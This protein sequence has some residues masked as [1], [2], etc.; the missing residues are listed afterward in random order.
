[1]TS[2]YIY[3]HLG[4][5]DNILC[6]GLIR[7]ISESYNKVYVFTKDIIAA[8]VMFMYK[9]NPK[10][11]IIS[12]SGDY[13]ILDFIKFNCEKYHILYLCKICISKKLNIYILDFKFKAENTVLSENK[14]KFSTHKSFNDFLS[15]TNE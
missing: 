15:Q 5:G 7:H 1:M 11:K 12:M 2:I 8:N 10:I 9:D 13:E 4:M 14:M 6:N 3:P